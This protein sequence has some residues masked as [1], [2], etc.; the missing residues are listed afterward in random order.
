M[1]IL[2]FFSRREATPEQEQR[3]A[4]LPNANQEKAI[5]RAIRA[6]KTIPDS[7][8]SPLPA[9]TDVARLIDRESG[10]GTRPVR[11]ASAMP[12]DTPAEFTLR[13]WDNPVETSFDNV[14]TDEGLKTLFAWGIV[15][16]YGPTLTVVATD[17]ILFVPGRKLPIVYLRF[18]PFTQE[19]MIIGE[20]C[21]GRRLTATPDLAPLSGVRLGG[22]PTL[23]LP[24]ISREPDEDVELYANFL[25]LFDD[26][27]RVFEEVRRFPS[28]PWNRVQEEMD[29]SFNIMA[30]ALKK[31]G[32]GPQVPTGRR[33]TQEE[34]RELASH[35]LE[36]KNLRAELDAFMYAWQGSIKLQESL[37]LQF[38]AKPALTLD[39]FAK[40]FFLLALGCRL[41]QREA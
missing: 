1:G 4:Q 15:N 30:S 22:C 21:I 25:T 17:G 14:G 36:P 12:G 28:D 2:D 20:A 23:L 37:G 31:D 10:Q 7:V 33:L 19:T 40:Q 27:S 41:P 38:L 13:L 8:W 35:L 39:E 6:G 26:G 16:S 18:N 32:L 11:S 5:L 29:K 24:S 9:G 3:L 34:A